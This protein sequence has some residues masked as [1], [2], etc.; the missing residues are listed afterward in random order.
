M[1]TNQN[2]AK[3]IAQ[4]IADY[5]SGNWWDTK[6]PHELLQEFLG[7]RPPECGLLEGGGLWVSGAAKLPDAESDRFVEWLESRG[8][9]PK[10]GRPRV[11]D[12]SDDERDAYGVLSSDGSKYYTVSYAGSG[13]EPPEYMALWDCDCPASQHGKS[14]KHFPIAMRY[15]D[16]LIAADEHRIEVE[17]ERKAWSTISHPAP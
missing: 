8:S 13:D 6:G 12:L 10:N 15:K 7:L 9:I 2:A 1:E 3:R 14:C 5:D 11:I 17:S 4:M 16:N